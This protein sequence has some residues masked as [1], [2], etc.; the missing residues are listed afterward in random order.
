M[1]TFEGIQYNFM[2]K[3]IRKIFQRQLADEM[4]VK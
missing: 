4:N 2:E 3:P 1:A